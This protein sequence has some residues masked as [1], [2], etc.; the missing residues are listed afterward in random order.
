MLLGASSEGRPDVASSVRLLFET[1]LAS[2][3]KKCESPQSPRPA[4][5]EGMLQCIKF[6][7]GAGDAPAPNL[8][9]PSMVF[10]PG[11]LRG[12][13]K[14]GRRS[15]ADPILGFQFRSDP[16]RAIQICVG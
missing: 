2:A 4:G 3:L 15:L 7:R 8:A 16:T 11:P 10:G 1:R 9:R 6:L 12:L 14:F 13:A 5:L